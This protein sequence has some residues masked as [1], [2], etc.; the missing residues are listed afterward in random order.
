MLINGIYSNENAP[1]NFKGLEKAFDKITP[2][3]TFK[4]N[5]PR[6]I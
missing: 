3:S 1:F 6:L 4:K 2:E 5:L